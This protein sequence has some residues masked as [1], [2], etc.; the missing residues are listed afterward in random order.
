[1]FNL[2]EIIFN[3]VLFYKDFKLINILHFRHLNLFLKNYKYL[4]LL[5]MKINDHNSN[6][7]KINFITIKKVIPLSVLLSLLKYLI[8]FYSLSINVFIR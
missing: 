5:I 7:D 2:Y 6:I 4:L 1:M 8:L 3:Y